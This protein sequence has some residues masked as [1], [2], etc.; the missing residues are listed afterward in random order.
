MSLPLVFLHGWGQSARIWFQQ[1]SAFPG[2]CYLNLPG[3][4]GNN[5]APA[6]EWV[7]TLAAALPDT[8][9]VLVG[10][11]L[12]GMLALDFTKRFPER[13]AALALVSTTPG[14]RQQPGWEHGCDDQ[15][16]AEFEQAAKAQTAKIMSRF[17]ALML[18]GDD[19]ARSDY[20]GLARQGIDRQNP[21]SKAGLEAGLSLLA[22]MDLRSDLATMVLPVLVM[23]GEQDAV[24]PVGAGRA[25]ASALPNSRFQSFSPCGHAPFLTQPQSFNRTLEAW[26]QTL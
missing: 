13:V 1:H 6:S 21:A 24:V 16:F 25:L 23:H 11:S 2:A 3:H 10:W 9:A 26:C 5:D 20:N 19:L 22:T 4:G 17:F 8:P 15:L 14:F 18:H 12:G 7:G